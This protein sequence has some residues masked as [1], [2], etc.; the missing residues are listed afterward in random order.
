MPDED[1][2]D[3][4][5][6]RPNAAPPFGGRS[7]LD[8]MMS[9]QVA[10]PFPRSA[11]RRRGVRR[12]GVTPPVARIAWRPSWRV[13]PSRFPTIAVFE[14]VAGPQDLEAVLELEALT[15]PRLRDEAGDIRLVPT[16]DRVWMTC[17]HHTDA[18]TFP[19]RS[20]WDRHDM[21][22]EVLPGPQARTATSPVRRD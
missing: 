2:A 3:E 5:V 4:W 17:D 11:V 16:E 19:R 12:L 21:Q 18:A 8:R 9:G 1:A 13:L 20:A 15:N 7:A 6:K 10:D 22:G 14:R